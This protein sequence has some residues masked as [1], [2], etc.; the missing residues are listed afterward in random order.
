MNHR[1]MTQDIGYEM[2]QANLEETIREDTSFQHLMA[3]FGVSAKMAAYLK[4]AMTPGEEAMELQ[5]VETADPAP[6][7]EEVVIAKEE[8]ALMAGYCLNYGAS[9]SVTHNTTP[10][11]RVESRRARYRRPVDV[12]FLDESAAW[13]FVI[14]VAKRQRQIERHSRH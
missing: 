11:E 7:P 3:D 10:F 6:T 8:E 1:E 2:Y 9:G 13:R 4:D 12:V 5:L 14:R